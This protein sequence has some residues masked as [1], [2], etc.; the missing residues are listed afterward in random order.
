MLFSYVLSET[1]CSLLGHR[2]ETSILYISG[3]SYCSEWSLS[4]FPL[5]RDPHPCGYM[6]TLAL[7]VG[8]IVGEMRGN[9]KLPLFSQTY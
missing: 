8:W 1:F 2:N 6:S 5:A 7:L 4:H 3:L 9:E